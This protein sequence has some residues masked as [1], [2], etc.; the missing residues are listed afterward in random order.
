[1]INELLFVYGS[2]LNA[3]NEFAGYLNSN[4]GLFST[5]KLKGK[6][7]DIGEYPGAVIAPDGNYE[8]SGHIYKLN[9]PQATL[10]I[11]DD[12]E[13]FGEDQEHPNLFVRK[14][15]PVETTNGRVYCWVY[16]YN[17]PVVGLKQIISGDYSDYLTKKP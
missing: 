14:C 4:A 6:L 13:G 15:L 11:L 5:G 10:K 12:Y 9:N 3:D 7:Y 16:L 17:L 8:I 1:M 2:L